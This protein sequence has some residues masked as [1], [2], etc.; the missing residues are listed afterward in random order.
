MRIHTPRPHRWLLAL[1][2]VICIATLPALER[3]FMLLAE[4][5]Y[6]ELRQRAERSPWDQMAADAI[7]DATTLDYDASVADYQ[8]RA[9]RARVIAASCALAYILDPDHAADYVARVESELYTGLDDLRTEKQDKKKKE[10]AYNVM[11]AGTAFVAYLCLDI[12]Y[13]DLDPTKRS[14]MEADCDYIADNHRDH[15]WDSSWHGIAGAKDLYHGDFVA[16][17]AHAD[18]YLA[19]LRKEI[20]ADGV[21]VQGCGYTRS[22]LTHEKRMQ[23]HVFMDLC[24]RHDYYDFY[25]D[26][27]FQKLYE[28]AYGYNLTPFRRAWTFGDAKTSKNHTWNLG[29]LK[30]HRFSEV[31]ARYARWA[32]G[33]FGP[34]KDDERRRLVHFVL[35]DQ[36]PASEPLQP[37]SRIFDDGGAWFYE[38]RDDPKALAIAMWNATKSE[39]HSHKDVNAINF[40][41][42]G[43]HV[44]RNSSYSGW[45]S[46]DWRWIHD[47]AESGNTVLIDDQ[48]HRA[49]TGAGIIEGLTGGAIDYA[50]G[51]SGDAL[52][53]GRHYRNCFFIHPDPDADLPGYAVLVDR[54]EADDAADTASI[55]LHPNSDR[56][57]EVLSQRLHYRL[58]HT[59]KDWVDHSAGVDIFYASRPDQVRVKTGF[60]AGKGDDEM[61]DARYLYATYPT[62]ESGLAVLATV[63][64][65]HDDDHPS[66]P[67]AQ[68]LPTGAT[69]GARIALADGVTDTVLCSDGVTGL[70]D[71]E[72]CSV[73]A[74]AALYRRR[75][76]VVQHYLVCRG[77]SFDDGGIR[78]RGF[79]CDQPISL[80]ASDAGAQVTLAAETTITWYLPGISQVR[81]AGVDLPILA[82]GEDHLS[83]S[84]PAGDHHLEFISATRRID[85]QNDA[86]VWLW[87][88]DPPDAIERVRDGRSRFGDLRPTSDYAL[89][90]VSSDDG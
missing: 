57:P 16:F 79:S 35:G 43:A 50:R 68:I 69:G 73:Q 46:G 85:L 63:L 81:L 13:D 29:A 75:H 60:L 12:M 52:R 90:A 54:V 51:D 33:P 20:T 25:N 36:E 24:V 34:E 48:D 8:D 55:A 26:P 19:Y 21:F 77:R 17:R 64:F 38:E 62:D 47:R 4:A 23:K 76:G 82:S 18:D 84:V 31:A 1:I 89:S 78:R 27:L 72:G 32:C 45:G 10:W 86:G 30:V 37:V 2:I 70:T 39:D 56:E 49:K 15:T 3:P 40:A 7:S 42:Y 58:D 83:V 88:I 65:P 22:R 66:R 87:E 6:A 44:L 14:A 61:D 9:E 28:W 41:A 11:P 71:D 5:D 80:S 53:G 74:E 67:M 59:G